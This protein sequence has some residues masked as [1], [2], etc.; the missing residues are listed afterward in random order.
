MPGAGRPLIR[1]RKP[2][3]PR[4]LAVP[5]AGDEQ[6]AGRWSGPWWR[7]KVALGPRT[8]RCPVPVLPSTCPHRRRRWMSSTDRQLQE[9]GRTVTRSY[10][11]FLKQGQINL[12]Q[13]LIHL[14]PDNLSLVLWTMD[15]VQ[16]SLVTFS[17]SVQC[18]HS[19]GGDTDNGD[20]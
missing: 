8:V 12:K 17:P 9:N 11:L 6:E 14:K 20:H 5:G 15:I 16:S 1:S 3:A 2:A 18:R 4:S 7:G 10:W 13:G 19:C